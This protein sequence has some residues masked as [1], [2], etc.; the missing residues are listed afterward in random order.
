MLASGGLDPRFVDLL[1]IL[2]RGGVKTSFHIYYPAASRLETLHT[3]RLA[4][5]DGVVPHPFDEGG[6]RLITWLRNAGEL[7]RILERALSPQP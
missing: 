4:E 1:P 3:L 7:N 6:H 2:S 5:I